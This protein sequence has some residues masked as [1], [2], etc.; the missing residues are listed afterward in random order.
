[1]N[2][3]SYQDDNFGTWHDMDD[4]DVQDFARQCSRN[5]VTKQCKQCE[6]TVR[7]LPQYAICNDCADANER[8]YG[9]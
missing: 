3:S 8:G 2:H 5:S 7:L 6:R 9:Y 1:M 4:P